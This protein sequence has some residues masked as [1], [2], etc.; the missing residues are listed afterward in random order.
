MVTNDFPP[1]AGGIESMVMQL[2]DGIDPERLVVHACRQDGD[3]A[4]DATLPFPVVRDPMRVLLPTPGLARRVRGTA[5]AY[6]ATRAWFPSSVPLGVLAPG[7][8]AVGVTRT[9]ATTHGHEVWWAALPGTRRVLRRSGDVN[10]F[11]TYIGEYTRSRIAPALSPA[12]AARMR[13]LHPT[14]AAADFTP[15]AGREA[16]RARYG[17]GEAPVVVC[18]SRLV[19]R[20]G[21]DRLIDA[22]P[23]VRRRVPGT[24]LL[25]VGAG[26]YEK[27]LRRRAA[28]LGDAVIFTG[29]APAGELAAHLAAGDV[30]AMP[31][32]TR[33]H[34][35]DVEGLGIVYL[36]ASAMGLP[37]VAGDSGGAPD[38]VREGETGF[39]V[40]G[41]DVPA[42]T[43]RLV[44]LLTHPAE[45][46]AMGRRGRD[47][48]LT[49]WRP[50][51]QSAQLRAMLDGGE[52]PA[53]S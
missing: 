29:R 26:P 21:Q 23:A 25:I 48:V 41:D 22:L 43:D 36:E 38:A 4:Y 12:A 18:V 50:R 2:L 5:L 39:V 34:G 52:E 47:W 37:V 53:Y 24:R 8:R 45:A 42:L 33:N 51:T 17:L 16:V 28:P 7:L 19:R 32:R 11:V 49:D 1:R 3:A 46:A 14:V 40:G 30:F 15:G 44:W 9:V 10:D 13:W 35:F 31:C 6:G 27:D 20:K